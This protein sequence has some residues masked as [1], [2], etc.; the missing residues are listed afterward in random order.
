MKYFNTI[1]A[2]SGEYKDGSPWSG[3]GVIYTVYDGKSVRYEGEYRN[4]KRNGVGKVCWSTGEEWTGTFKD[5]APW[6]GKGTWFYSDGKKT[7]RF[8]LGN[9]LRF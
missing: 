8:V 4:G 6:N 7:G 5:G 9:C 1:N 2:W 3:N